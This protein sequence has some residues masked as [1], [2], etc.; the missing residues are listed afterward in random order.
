MTEKEW[1]SSSDPESMVIHLCRGG[2]K[3][4]LR[5]F[6][7]ACTRQVWPLISDD[8]FRD[9]VVVAERFADGL[10]RNKELAVAKSTSG[11]ALE[12]HG[13]AGERAP[14]QCALGCAWSTTRN[15][16]SAAIYPLWVF[17]NDDERKWQL[18]ILRD[19]FGNPFRNVTLDIS[20]LSTEV[21][22][23]AATVYEDRA[24]ERMPELAHALERSN[25][26]NAEV[27]NHCRHGHIHVRGCWVLD[28][29][30]AKD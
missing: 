6:G 29:I 28:L 26:G 20:T 23:L 3:R 16:E 1:L 11:A 24:F 5:L 19:M 4:K 9:A 18:A 2:S 8:C 27:L 12:R 7:C 15:P 14:I 22:S 21:T 10:V 25:C 30:L 17:T 13:L